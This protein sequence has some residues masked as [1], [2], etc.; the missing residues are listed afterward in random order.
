MISMKSIITDWDY[1]YKNEE[2][3]GKLLETPFFEKCVHLCWYMAIQDPVMYLAE[4]IKPDTVYNRDVY[5][6]FVQSGDK[7]KYVVWPALFLHEDGP[8]LYKGVVQAYKWFMHHVIRP[9]LSHNNFI[10]EF[11]IKYSGFELIRLIG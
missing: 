4:E 7:V 9:F 11:Y 6:E 2:L 10:N 5:K 3:I 1:I 8:L